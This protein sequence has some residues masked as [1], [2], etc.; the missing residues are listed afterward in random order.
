VAI[1][2]FP[3]SAG[4]DPSSYN[5]A[6]TTEL[7]GAVPVDIAPGVYQVTVASSGNI[8]MGTNT[9]TNNTTGTYFV[10]TPQTSMT[11]APLGASGVVPWSGP[12]GGWGYENASEYTVK[13]LVFGNDL[14]IIG[15]YR[16]TGRFNFAPQ[17]RVSTTGTGSWAH[18]LNAS[19][20]SS[21]YGGAYGAGRYVFGTVGG[22][23]GGEL[24][25]S[26]NA[27]HWERPFSG[28][29]YFFAKF[30]NNRF[31]AGGDSGVLR[32]S[33]DGLTWSIPITAAD[34]AFQDRSMRCAAFGNGVYVV[35]GGEG[36]LITSTDTV[37]W[38]TRN[39][40]AVGNWL[41]AAAFG[42]GTFVVAGGGQ[43]RTSTDGVTWAIRTFGNQEPI[44]D[45]IF[46]AGIFIAAGRYS[47]QTS[48]DGATWTLRTSP[49]LYVGTTDYH[50][51]GLIF[52]NGRYLM[53]GM[54]NQPAQSGYQHA[55]LW[56]T[57]TFGGSAS[58]QT[59]VLFEKK[60]EISAIV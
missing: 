21:V 20:N 22:D 37:T 42:N 44:Y 55:I 12:T 3:L 58:A 43:L 30:L 59:R 32:T 57:T 8:I 13:P 28:Q 4:G 53:G 33:T 40:N 27:Y 1:S 46:Q 38:T 18:P 60:S 23:L 2:Q 16:N 51:F 6:Y 39:S 9:L 52:G 14:Y 26:T 10:T 17:I 7:S 50:A 5:K 49:S 29:N 36:Q 19:N 15:I 54:N 48:V 41:E 34:T 31:L 35:A 24:W 11:I 25:S 56:N 47:V 45:I